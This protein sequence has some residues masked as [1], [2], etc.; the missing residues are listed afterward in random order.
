MCIMGGVS[1]LLKLQG[2]KMPVSQSISLSTNALKSS[3]IIRMKYNVV[4]KH[5]QLYLQHHQKA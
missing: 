2:I 3:S 4:I 1:Q 5:K